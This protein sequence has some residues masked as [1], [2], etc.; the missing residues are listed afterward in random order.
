MAVNSF[1]PPGDV[2]NEIAVVDGL[3]QRLM[4]GIENQ[5]GGGGQRNISVFSRYWIVNTTEHCLRYK[6]ENCN[7]FVSGNVFSPSRDGSRSI[8]SGRSHPRVN[9]SDQDQAVQSDG[10]AIFAGKPGALATCD[11]TPKEIAPLL[12]RDLSLRQ[13]SRLAF[14]F[15]FQDGNVMSMGQQRLCVKLSDGRSDDDGYE[16]DWSRG[17]SMDSI[18]ISQ[19]VAMHCKDGRT[20]ELTMVL[21]KPLFSGK[22]KVIRFLPRYL[23]VNKLP[24][25]V[26]IYQD[27]SL[28]RGVP[29]SNHSAVGTRM[30]KW[31]QISSRRSIESAEPSQYQS[32]WGVDKKVAGKNKIHRSSACRRPAAF[33]TT[34]QPS[35]ILPFF[36]P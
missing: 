12:E 1:I 27:S 19:V 10:H 30:A 31:R 13:L 28:D 20:L 9:G 16:S 32:L 36:L 34:V 5:R 3:G 6:Q 35:E 33:V 22:T 8:S 4:I 17:L 11:G 25:P 29:E 14:M 15:S 24:Y 18:G 7:S 23:V 21:Q 2:A 26:R